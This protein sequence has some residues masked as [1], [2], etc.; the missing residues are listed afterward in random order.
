MTN[1][2]AIPPLR[3]DS[4]GDVLAAVPA[5]LGFYPTR[6]VVLLAHDEVT[7][8]IGATARVDLGLTR[9]GTLRVDCRRHL[10]AAVRLLRQQG[11]DRLLCVVVEERSLA[12]A[13]PA[14]VHALEEHLRAVDADEEDLELLDLIFVP[15]LAGGERWVCRHGE[16]GRMA[17][18]A[19]SPATLAAAF[20]GRPVRRSRD[21]LIGLLAEEGPGVGEVRCRDVAA[22]EADDDPGELLDAV[23]AAV[24]AEGAAGPGSLSDDDVALL[25]G[26][27]LH[28]AVR[29]AAMA[30][31]LTV[32]AAEARDL[33]GELARRL[34]G[35]PRAAAATLV[36]SVAYAAGD[37]PLTGI[38]LEAALLADPTYRAA[39]LMASAFDAGMRPDELA[40]ASRAGFGVAYRLGIV[41]PPEEG[42]D[43]G[44]PMTG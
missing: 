14:L 10:G 27:V 29:D 30:L 19:D 39:I 33:F 5:L 38:A 13:T 16:S 15:V 9:A 32:V 6:S 8:R 4:V 43:G 35:A 42:R 31:G 12:K 26:A 44:F 22:H 25:G 11:V 36:A 3:L 24:T 28:T 34:R 17:D 1:Q 18:P 7:R 21:E 20:A 37:G 41:L 40:E 2:H 23:V